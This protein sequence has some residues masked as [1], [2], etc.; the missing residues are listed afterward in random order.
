MTGKRQISQKSNCSELWSLPRETH[1]VEI[2][3]ALQKTYFGPKLAQ[4]P[5]CY[6]TSDKNEKNL[7]QI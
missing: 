7:E 4:N 2:F 6:N 5:K 3:F 1:I